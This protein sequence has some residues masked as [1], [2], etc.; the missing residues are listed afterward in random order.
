MASLGQ[1]VTVITHGIN[2]P[3]E[4]VNNNMDIVRSDMNQ[5]DQGLNKLSKI[6]KELHEVSP[7]SKYVTQLIK[8]LVVDYRQGHKQQVFNEVNDLLKESQHGLGRVNE[9]VKS[10]KG[11]FTD[12]NSSDRE[13]YDVNDSLKCIIHLCKPLLKDVLVATKL[14]GSLIIECSS[15]EMNQALMNIII[16][17]VQTSVKSHL[18]KLSISTNL[19]AEQYVQIIFDDNTSC[20][21]L[22]EFNEILDPSL[23]AKEETNHN[24]LGLS[25]AYNTIKSH[26]GNVEINSRIKNGVSFVVTLPARQSRLALDLAS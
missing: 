21:K 8:D 7:D 1:M 16:G 20:M 18:H 10:L 24:N 11:Y 23:T 13:S 15:I 22:E 5:L 3:L 6:S 14:K 26:G 2:T 17:I 12:A 25:V 4:C 19:T 9:L